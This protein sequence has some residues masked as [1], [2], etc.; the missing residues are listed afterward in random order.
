MVLTH[1]CDREFRKCFPRFYCTSIPCTLKT[2]IS[3]SDFGITGGSHDHF[4]VTPI[5]GD[6]DGD[7][8]QPQR[9]LLVWG[10]DT[11]ISLSIAWRGELRRRNSKWHG[12]SPTATH[13]NSAWRVLILTPPLMKENVAHH[14]S[15][16]VTPLHAFHGICF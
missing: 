11:Q 10:I 1:V 16:R 2:R 9:A 7:T 6:S 15:A 13:N 8:R 3:L 14:E 5:D 12:C 4:A